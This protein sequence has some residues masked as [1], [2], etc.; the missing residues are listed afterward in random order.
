PWVRMI[1]VSQSDRYYACTCPRCKAAYKKRA[2]RFDQPGRPNG[3]PVR[4]SWPCNTWT[5]ENATEAA[6]FMD[7]VNRIAREV[8]KE[9]PGVYVHTL[10]Y[11]W[12]R[13]P[14]VN[15]QPE[16]NVIVDYEPLWEC[17]F[18]SMAQC[19]NN[20]EMNGFWTTF[21]Q[22]KKKG[23]KL[24]VWDGAYDHSVKPY[25]VLHAGRNQY[26]RELKIAGVDGIRVH[27]A[28]GSRQWLGDLRAYLYAKLLWNP[29]FDIKAG[30][31]EYCKHAYGKASK[32]MTEYALS[33]QDPA[34]YVWFDWHL[35]YK[36]RK[37]KGFHR[38]PSGWVKEDVRAHWDA[39]YKKAMAA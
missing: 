2:G 30:I 11:Y 37:P 35:G 27:M 19:R 8:K 18:H 9:F 33:T 10:G 1:S 39:L 4:P 6:V 16:S 28:G 13:Y 3:K 23:V 32:Y 31:A 36:S 17:R 14:L 21:R 29:D 5:A 24:H 7:F 25:P 38:I 34:S 15:C 12:T 22:W 26:Y 20:D